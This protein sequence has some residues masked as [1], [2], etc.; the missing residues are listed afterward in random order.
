MTQQ[1]L[2]Y[3]AS[4][5]KKTILVICLLVL[6]SFTN[7]DIR[8][9]YNLPYAPSSVF[10]ADLDL[11]G[12]NDLIVGHKTAWQ[13]TNPTITVLD[14][15]DH[16]IFEITDTAKCFCGYQYNIF[17]VDLNNDS[18]PDIVT[19]HV[20]FSSGT[21][22]NYIRVFY[23]YKGTFRNFTDFNLNSS[24]IMD[25]I[26]YGDIDGNGYLDIIVASNTS[27]FW[28]VL[29]N[30]GKGNFSAPVYHNISGS[31]P[32]GLAC[33]DLNKDGRDD[34]IVFGVK[35]EL[36][37]SLATGFQ[38]VLLCK[39]QRDGWIR[40]INLDG[41]SD[42]V[43]C[44]DRTVT[45]FENTGSGNFIQHSDV[46][47]SNNSFHSCLSDFN[48]DSLP[49]VLLQFDNGYLIYYN[50]GNFHLGDSA[51][52]PVEYMGEWWRNCCSSDLDGNGYKDIVTVR[53]NPG[54]LDIK[55]NDGKGHFVDQPLA[56][57]DK[58][59]EIQLFK[60]FPNPFSDQTTFEFHLSKPEHVNLSIYD[61][62]GNLFI[63]M[64]DEKMEAGKQT[65]S[66]KLNDLN[67]EPCSPGYYFAALK[68]NGEQKGTLKLLIY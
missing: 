67:G 64:I 44:E 54:N 3:M 13:K 42:I 35:V 15:I 60:S 6:C 43:C 29:Y 56:I 10:A 26:S 39:Q 25:K 28:G 50:K 12:D 47:L 34:I 52:I 63:C 24:A 62:G 1:D 7:G 40:D 27:Q 59:N 48:N 21:V 4:S 30:D 23:N 33:G 45:I 58:I 22:E 66:W 2:V 17:A 31:Y 49:D 5:H 68:L 8:S 51:F 57:K 16:G 20:D 37:Y 9:L 36:Y 61:A 65:L 38:E 55:F 11:D 14:N 19:A 41:N 18:F 32:T 53:Y 46:L